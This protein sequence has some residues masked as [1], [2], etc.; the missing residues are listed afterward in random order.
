M[1]S[2]KMFLMNVSLVNE[3]RDNTHALRRAKYMP[4]TNHVEQSQDVRSMFLLNESLEVISTPTGLSG[5]RKKA[6]AGHDN[7]GGKHGG[8]QN[9]AQFCPFSTG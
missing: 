6:I 4:E 8:G 2:V 3:S 5:V 9:S 1:Y 7:V